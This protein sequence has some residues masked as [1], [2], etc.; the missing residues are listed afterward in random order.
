MNI[1]I[2]QAFIKE[3]KG[4]DIDKKFKEL[5]EYSLDFNKKNK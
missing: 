2:L 5:I 1:K 3:Y 4:I